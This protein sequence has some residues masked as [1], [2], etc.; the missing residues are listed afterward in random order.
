MPLKKYAVALNVALLAFAAV[1]QNP[2]RLWDYPLPMNN[3]QMIPRAPA[4]GAEG[5]VYFGWGSQMLAV[6]TNGT[7]Q[8]SYDTGME[9]VTCP[10]LAPDGTI[11]FCAQSASYY[12]VYPYT[13]YTN[14]ALTPSGS[15]AYQGSGSGLLQMAIGKHGEA[16]QGGNSVSTPLGIFS[17]FNYGGASNLA[18][19]K[20]GRTYFGGS[21]GNFYCVGY[22]DRSGNFLP[23]WY[24][25]F[26]MSFGQPVL[27]DGMVFF[28][29]ANGSSFLYGLPTRSG[30]SSFTADCAATASPVVDQNN[31]VYIGEND[32]TFS[33][34]PTRFGISGWSFA[35]SNSIIFAAALGAN[36]YAYFGSGSNL[37]AVDTNGVEQWQFSLP[38]Q[39]ASS[40][41]ISGNG[42]L[43][44]G[45]ESTLTALQIFTGPAGG[46]WPMWG[47]DLRNGFRAT[48]FDGAH[49][50][51]EYMNAITN[52]FEL[53]ACCPP[54]R[55]HIEASTNLE[56][57]TVLTNVG[58]ANGTLYLHDVNPTLTRRFYKISSP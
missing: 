45:T 44:I 16:Y 53:V 29:A 15:V 32:G 11:N 25:Y 22:S 13:R 36:G 10:A 3:G 20:D 6:N 17:L 9:E 1:A 57:W 31:S 37:F 42:V 30:G 12:P 41:I 39:V 47:C 23:F 4:I 5:T 27:G 48:P 58:S 51:I 33:C 43:Y 18:V 38:D 35:T 8:W 26:D 49:I 34:F 56:D 21:D 7:L 54:G 40:P 24:D 19:D 28:T 55:G 14:Y 50:A 2:I 52:G 46:R